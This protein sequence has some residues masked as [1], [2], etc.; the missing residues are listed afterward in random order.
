MVALGTQV[1]GILGNDEALVD[2]LVRH[3]KAAGES[4]WPLPLVKEYR[5]E[6]K[7]SV[8]DLK[9][10]GGGYAGTITA[11]LFLQEFVEG[12]KWAHLDIA[13]PAFAERDLAYCPRG[14][15]GFGIRTL[16]R[17]LRSR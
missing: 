6:L 11:A 5:D 8:A 14:G 16:L 7:S 1:A 3:G 13:G 4:L 17:Y 15:T 12:A 9:N 10:V 2:E